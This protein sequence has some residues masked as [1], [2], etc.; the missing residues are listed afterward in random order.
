MIN[1]CQILQTSV[2]RFKGAKIGMQ[3]SELAESSKRLILK[4]EQMDLIEYATYGNVSR[5][6]E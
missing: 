1:N 6:V 5:P 2:N 4:G 3:D